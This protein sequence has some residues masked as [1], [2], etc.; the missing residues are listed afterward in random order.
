MAIKK[1]VVGPVLEQHQNTI[2][3]KVTSSIPENNL[4]VNFSKL[5]LKPVCIKGKFNNHFKNDQHF[6]SVAASFLGV[7]LPKIT[8]HSYKELLD[9]SPEAKVLH[10]HTV[11]EAHRENV[12][13]VLEEYHFPTYAI[14]QM[15]E[16]NN[17]VEFSASLGHINPARIV[18][19][20]VN[21]VLLPLFFDTNHHIY[22]NEKYVKDSMF[23]ESCPEYLS[24]RCPYMPTDCFA[25]GYLNEE[26]LKESYEYSFSHN[27]TCKNVLSFLDE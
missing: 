9:S 16:R 10:Y 11:D 19:H 22:L 14:E 4:I 20:K 18:C 6:S 2:A 26:L 7:V 8:S 13:E 23:Y 5:Q 15:L 25:F 12:R 21:N 24:K 17:I 1:K 27:N 3:D